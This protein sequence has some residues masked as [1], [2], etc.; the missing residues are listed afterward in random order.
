VQYICK[1]YA[2]RAFR[3]RDS[4]RQ[5]ANA[6][7]LQKSAQIF[8]AFILFYFKCVRGINVSCGNYMLQ[9]CLNAFKKSIAA[10]AN[11]AK[12]TENK[13][14]VIIATRKADGGSDETVAYCSAQCQKAPPGSAKSAK[15][16]VCSKVTPPLR[17]VVSSGVRHQ[18]CSDACFTKFRHDNHV[19][20]D[21]CSHCGKVTTPEIL[22]THTLQFNGT[23]RQFCGVVCMAA[24]RT[25]NKRDARCEWCGTTRCNFDMV[26]RVDAGGGPVKLFCSLNCLS[27]FRVNQQ[28]NSGQSVACDQCHKLGTAQYHLTMSDASVRNFCSYPCVASFQAQF[29]TPAA[30][31]APTPSQKVTVAVSAAAASSKT[32]SGYGTRSR[33]VLFSVIRSCEMK[34]ICNCCFIRSAFSA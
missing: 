27:L 14:G 26:E 18:L 19:V 22:T 10:C 16:S 11:C 28:A 34:I 33:G 5:Y 2:F 29:A 12:E 32:A 9:D 15:C 3:Q 6:K 17:E 20:A 21:D 7:S 8:G 24:F 13:S 1:K 23:S 25:Q 30:S 31:S 4:L